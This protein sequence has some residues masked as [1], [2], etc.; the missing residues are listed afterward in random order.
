MD[1]TEEEAKY[2]KKVGGYNKAVKLNEKRFKY[3]TDI[4]K[5]GW[6]KWLDERQKQFRQK[7]AALLYLMPVQHESVLTFLEATHTDEVFPEG[8]SDDLVQGYIGFVVE[9]CLE[10]ILAL[11]G[12]PMT[13][14]G[15]V[16]RML[17]DEIPTCLMACDAAVQA[18]EQ[19]NLPATYPGDLGGGMYLKRQQ[20][21]EEMGQDDTEADTPDFES[22]LMRLPW[23]V[24]EKFHPDTGKMCADWMRKVF[25][26]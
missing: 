20:A 5:K 21:G 8:L 2:L 13:A 19:E 6:K 25:E 24:P 7:V 15:A 14:P 23:R 1:H 10:Y 17:K 18:F 3:A 9:S 16:W 4:V 22:A 12:L 11:K 26:L